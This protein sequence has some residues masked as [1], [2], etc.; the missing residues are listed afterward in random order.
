[1]KKAPLLLVWLVACAGAIWFHRS[2]AV[3]AKNAFQRG[4]YSVL[5]DAERALAAG[6]SDLALARFRTAY[7]RAR[8]EGQSG[9][10]ER[11]RRR[12][13]LAGKDLA[14][15]DPAKGWPFLEMYALLSPDFGR[16]A[17]AVEEFCLSECPPGW[18]RFEYHL[19]RPDGRSAWGVPWSSE[20]T[21]LWPWLRKWDSTV[22]KQSVDHLHE[23]ALADWPRSPFVSAL[24]IHLLRGPLDLPATTFVETGSAR[25]RGCWFDYPR[26]HEFRP[27]S[28]GGPGR[29]SAS[30]VPFI[31]YDGIPRFAV[32]SSAL[33]PPRGYRVVLVRTYEAL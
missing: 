18:N 20:W 19:T 7:V 25:V 10:A 17:L 8:Y 16:D 5:L 6:K 26:A 14:R 15:K 12:V 3:G 9:V 27:A 13:A 21:G 31:P 28:P 22:G 30:G 4:S 24:A 33:P 32:F 2:P 23:D 11:I 29:W 1:M